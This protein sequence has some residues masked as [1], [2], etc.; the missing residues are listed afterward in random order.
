MTN[1][2]ILTKNEQ[3]I[4]NMADAESSA[5]ME[6]KTLD[7]AA[8]A[9]EKVSR[10]VDIDAYSSKNPIFFAAGRRRRSSVIL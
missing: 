3:S 10:S 2:L 4:L 9:D 7:L 5:E 1:D 6:S 8:Q